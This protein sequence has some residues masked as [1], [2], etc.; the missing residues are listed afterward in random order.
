MYFHLEKAVQDSSLF[1]PHTPC[2]NHKIPTSILSTRWK[3]LEKRYLEE[4]APQTPHGKHLESLMNK[5]LPI[6]AFFL[7]GF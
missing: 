2:S 1:L 4:G 7:E 6:C 3:T 5:K